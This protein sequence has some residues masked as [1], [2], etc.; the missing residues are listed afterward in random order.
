VHQQPFYEDRGFK[1]GDFS[2]VENFHN[3]AISI[4]VYSS[5]SLEY[6]AIVINAL[7]GIF[8]S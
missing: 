5:L 4:P 3:E 8:L 1:S 2:E 7:N 6:Q